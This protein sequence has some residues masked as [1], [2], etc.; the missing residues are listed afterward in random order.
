VDGE[1]G[2][3]HAVHTGHEGGAVVTYAWTVYATMTAVV[4]AVTGLLGTALFQLLARFD[5]LSDRFD[6]RFEAIDRRFD[7]VDRRLDA[8][9]LRQREDKA[10]ILGR[11]DVL[12]ER[13][14]ALEAR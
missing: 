13:V 14:I 11:L 4:L 1:A 12:A 7:G 9:E 5:R 10:E 2:S 6:Q 3:T 8:I